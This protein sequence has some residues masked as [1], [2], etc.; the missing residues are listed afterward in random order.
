MIAKKS[1]IVIDTNGLI[2]ATGY[3]VIANCI[4]EFAGRCSSIELEIV[5]VI[6]R[7]ST[8]ELTIASSF[9]PSSK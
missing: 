9:P 5:C 6:R 8:S 7:M 3:E 1:G 2:D 4:K